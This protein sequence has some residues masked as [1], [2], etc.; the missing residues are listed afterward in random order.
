M[1]SGGRAS[2]FFA[3]IDC[4]VP[5]ALP[6]ASKYC[7]TFFGPFDVNFQVGECGVTARIA[8]WRRRM[9]T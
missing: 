1:P 7:V 6:I 5:I 3:R 4:D 8:E 2:F 9:K